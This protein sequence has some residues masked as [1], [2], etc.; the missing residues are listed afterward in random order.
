[1]IVS[2]PIPNLKMVDQNV[3]CIFN[4]L[5]VARRISYTVTSDFTMRQLIVKVA[6]QLDDFHADL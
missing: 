6:E 3:Y 2:V 4:A 1:M 5:F